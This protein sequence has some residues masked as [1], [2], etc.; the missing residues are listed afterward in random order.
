MTAFTATNIVT[1]TAAGATPA[2]P[3]QIS[4]WG[5]PDTVDGSLIGTRGVMAIVT[6]TSGGS[7]DF[8]VGDPGVTPAGNPASNGY[9]ATPVPT[10]QT[11]WV[12]ITQANVNSSGVAQIGASSTAAGFT[13][14]FAR[15]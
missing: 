8:R 13:V 1:A 10:G 15:Y 14:Q 12:L 11:R 4:A 9:S 6:N 5:T 2:A 3:V 7:L